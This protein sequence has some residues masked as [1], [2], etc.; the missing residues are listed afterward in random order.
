[1]STKHAYTSLVIDNCFLRDIYC[2][3]AWKEFQ[4]PNGRNFLAAP[5][6]LATMINVDWFQPFTHV[7][8]SVGVIYLVILTLPR[9]ERYKLENIIVVGIIPGPKEPKK[10]VNSFLVP[11]MEDLHKFWNGVSMKSIYWGSSIINCC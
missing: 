10:N 1:M 2:G 11:L 3:E 8:Y 6:S 7:K 4:C 5:Y 9:E